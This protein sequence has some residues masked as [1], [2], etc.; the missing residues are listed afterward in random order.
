LRGPTIDFDDAC[1]CLDYR[2]TCS[3]RNRPDASSRARG[4][5]GS[6]LAGFACV[7]R[8]HSA[9]AGIAAG[10]SRKCLATLDLRRSRCVGHF[11]MDRRIFSKPSTVIAIRFWK[12]K[13]TGEGRAGM[14]SACEASSLPPNL[15]LLLKAAIRIRLFLAAL[16]VA[17]YCEPLR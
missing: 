2:F 6:V 11:D 3:P 15:A 9:N 7:R 12:S 14:L 17:P 1:N 16:G 8:A 13:L 4:V 5:A 10:I